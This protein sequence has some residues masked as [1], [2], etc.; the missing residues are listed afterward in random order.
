MINL[1]DPPEDAVVTMCGHVFCYQCVSEY[2]SG[3]ENTC[4][5][6]ECKELLGSDVIFS[7]ATLRSCLYGNDHLDVSAPSEP[8]KSLVLQ[9]GYSSSKIKAA[10]EILESHCKSNNACSQLH[11]IVERGDIFSSC[12]KETSDVGGGVKVTNA[13][14][15]SD[16][17]PE[18][19]KKAIVFS[20]WTGMLD[21]V[22]ISLNQ[23]ALRYRRLDGTMTL[24]A[25]D[26]AV[27]EFNNDPE[28]ELLSFLGACIVILYGHV[29]NTWWSGS[30]I[31][32]LL[33]CLSLYAFNYWF[34]TM[35]HDFFHQIK[36]KLYCK[37]NT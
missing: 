20:Q 4:P 23:S 24:S 28:V 25:R 11:A 19:P 10:M 7:K 21:L 16:A 33:Q 36:Y 34:Y 5:S 2:L 12:G 18:A 6:P 29:C 9:N 31:V 8:N 14:V 22:E 26:K 17:H 30:C 3:D 32:I 15:W 35:F 13:I 27:K 1:Q 37:V